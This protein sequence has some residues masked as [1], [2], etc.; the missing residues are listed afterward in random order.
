[1]ASA[2][3]NDDW[4][5][6][7]RRWYFDERVGPADPAAISLASDLAGGNAPVGYEAALP[8]L[9]LAPG[10]FDANRGSR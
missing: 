3:P 4:L 7:V 9:Q 8:A 1:M 6:D 5:A 2:A 10:E